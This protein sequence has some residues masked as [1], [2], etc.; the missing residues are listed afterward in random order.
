MESKEKQLQLN[1]FDHMTLLT[2]YEEILSKYLLYINDNVVEFM[3][4]T[5]KLYLTLSSFLTI[6]FIN[7]DLYEK[8]C[9]CLSILDYCKLKDVKS[10][11]KPK[12]KSDFK[13]KWKDELN[14]KLKLYDLEPLTGYKY[15]NFNDGEYY[16]DE[17]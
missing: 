6:P 16:I 10:D 14:K 2:N 5:K 7:E 4:N 17:I 13:P 3:D 1:R 8:I 9:L 15:K 12:W 11:F